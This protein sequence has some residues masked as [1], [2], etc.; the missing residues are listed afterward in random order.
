MNSDLRKYGMFWDLIRKNH[1]RKARNFENE[2]SGLIERVNKTK[3]GRR[4]FFELPM[5][6][7]E[8]Y[9]VYTIVTK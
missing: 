5:K 8:H 3:E 4:Y 9:L 1:F 6:V 2:N 7:K